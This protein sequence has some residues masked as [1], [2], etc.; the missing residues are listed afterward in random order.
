MFNFGKTNADNRMA[1]AFNFMVLFYSLVKSYIIT[2]PEITGI[3]FSLPKVIPFI[4]FSINAKKLLAVGIPSANFLSPIV[5][6]F[7]G[8]ENMI[9]S[10]P[11]FFLIHILIL[12]SEIFIVFLFKSYYLWFLLCFVQQLTYSCIDLTLDQVST[13]EPEDGCSNQSFRSN[14]AVIGLMLPVLSLILGPYIGMLTCFLLITL[15]LTLLLFYTAYISL[16]LQF[17]DQFDREKSSDK[18]SDGD[19]KIAIPQL[20]LIVIMI[21]AMSIPDGVGDAISGKI[22]KEY[23]NSNLIVIKY[24]VM[25][26]AWGLTHP[27]IHKAVTKKII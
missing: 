1:Y 9:K 3:G 24:T 6:F 19:G 20:L 12:W 27:L 23:K 2:H 18:N 26:I 11:I 16:K 13:K 17:I 25:A 7:M 14:G 21:L 5:Q 22:A 4:F 10:L 15:I 8:R